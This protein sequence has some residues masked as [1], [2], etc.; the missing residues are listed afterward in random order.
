MGVWADGIGKEDAPGEKATQGGCGSHMERS[1]NARKKTGCA[2]LLGG[3]ILLLVIALLLTPRGCRRE[4]PSALKSW[5]GGEVT[6]TSVR[7]ALSSA[8]HKL[9]VMDDPDF[10]DNIDRVDVVD[11]AA[12]GEGHK[13]VAIFFKT[14]AT[15]ET[16]LLEKV[17]GTFI[18]ACSV[19]YGNPKVETVS[20]RAMAQMRDELGNT[21]DEVV[22]RLELS[23]EVARKINWEGLA[24]RHSGDPGNIYRIATDYYVHPAVLA[25]ANRD[26]IRL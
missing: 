23:R 25:N 19:L 8:P 26:R 9:K 13:N 24:T 17:G 3:F 21:S 10:P 5:A 6:E 15:S 4:D 2:A 1:E 22:A 18:F 14:W 12:A 20:L 7:A 16:A 11:S